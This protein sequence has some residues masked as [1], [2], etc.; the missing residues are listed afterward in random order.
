MLTVRRGKGNKSFNRVSHKAFH[1]YNKDADSQ[2]RET[3][4]TTWNHQTSFL[5]QD[6]VTFLLRENPPS[7]LA[8]YTLFKKKMGFPVT[9]RQPRLFQITFIYWLVW[10]FCT[11]EGH[12]WPENNAQQVNIYLHII[13]PFSP[14][15][16]L[17]HGEHKKIR[18]YQSIKIT[19][20]WF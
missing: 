16:L 7:P 5:C 12:L 10:P 4:K 11:E 20:A 9:I 8:I 1:N 2:E 19:A 13:S 6:F 3:M 18:I 17:L 15:I 14:G